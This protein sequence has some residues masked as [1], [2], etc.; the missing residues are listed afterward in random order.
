MKNVGGETIV[1]ESASN[2]SANDSHQY[3]VMRGSD[4][5]S[6]S[7]QPYHVKLSPATSGMNVFAAPEQNVRKHTSSKE[8]L[9]KSSL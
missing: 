6:H 7:K 9:A 3:Q 8:L 1:S 2:V 5:S 4:L